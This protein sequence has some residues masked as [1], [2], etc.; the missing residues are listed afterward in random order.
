MNKIAAVINEKETSS[1]NYL[2]EALYEYDLPEPGACATIYSH[3]GSEQIQ[4][5]CPDRRNI[6]LIN[7][8][9]SFLK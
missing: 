9:V 7:E 8:N 3:D 2:L 5:N 6:P 4:F 1:L